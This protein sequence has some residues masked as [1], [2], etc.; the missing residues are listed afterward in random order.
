M[1]DQMEMVCCRSDEEKPD[2]PVSVSEMEKR[3]TEHPAVSPIKLLKCLVRLLMNCAPQTSNGKRCL[4]AACQDTKFLSW[5]GKVH[6]IFKVAFLLVLCLYSPS[7][8]LVERGTRL[9]W[10]GDH[11]KHSIVDCYALF[12]FLYSVWAIGEWES[13]LRRKYPNTMALLLRKCLAS[14]LFFAEGTIFA[15]FK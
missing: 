6:S 9:N 8:A 15:P 2:Q 12:C 4:A 7:G 10:K 14:Q 13:S 5:I 1:F 11:Q 3:N